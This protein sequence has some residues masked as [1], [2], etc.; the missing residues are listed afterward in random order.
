MGT[1]KIS[2]YHASH[3]RHNPPASQRVLSDLNI[4]VSKSDFEIWINELWDD[5]EVEPTP[6]LVAS[7]LF[8]LVFILLLVEYYE[9][10]WKA[11]C[12]MC[13]LIPW[14]ENL[15]LAF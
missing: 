2:N 6:Y 7:A 3:F 14:D 13:M 11:V 1:G 9:I 12:L 8:Y 5:A 15:D 4:T 10:V